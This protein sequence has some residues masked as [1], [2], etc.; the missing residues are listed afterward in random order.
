MITAEQAREMAVAAKTAR[1]TQMAQDLEDSKA[2]V[3]AFLEGD[4]LQNLIE[5]AASARQPSV[6]LSMDYVKRIEGVKVV[7]GQFITEKLTEKLQPEGYKVFFN[8]N[9]II[10]WGESDIAGHP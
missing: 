5:G 1:R 8:E 3:S 6:T 2:A 10:Y 4:A 7:D 9:W